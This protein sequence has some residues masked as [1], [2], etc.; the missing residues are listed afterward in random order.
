MDLMLSSPAT[1]PMEHVW[2][3]ED[4][5]VLYARTFTG[6]VFQTG[7]F[8][9]WEPAANPPAPPPMQRAS[10]VRL[11]EPGAEIFTASNNPS[12]LWAR[13]RQLSRSDDGGRSWVDLT[14]YRSQSVVGPGQRSVAVSPSDADQIV[15]ANDYGVWRSMDGGL[16]WAGLNES[17]PN[18]AVRRIVSTPTGVAGTRVAVENLGVLE[19]PHGGNVW[20][21][22]PNIHLDEGTKTQQYSAIVRADVTAFGRSDEVVFAGSGDG[23]IWVS[24]DGGASFDLTTMPSG[25]TGRVERIYVNAQGSRVVALAALS[26]SGPRVLRTTNGGQFWDVLDFNLPAGSAYA[27]TA[28]RAAGAVFVATDKGVYY[29][30]AD[31]EGASTNPVNWQNLTGGLPA[32][33]AMDV[34]L[35]PAAVQ[36][37]IALEGYGVY[38]ASAPHRRNSLQ[39]VNAA[40][41]STRAAAPGSLLSVI[42]MG[43]NAAAGGG[44][45]YPVLAN[46]LGE[47]QIQVPFEAEGPNVAL[48]LQTASGRVLRD[49]A[50]QPVSPAILLLDREG[51]PALYD[52]DSGLALDGRNAA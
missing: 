13:G 8:E 40:D 32:A 34:M 4:G 26:G 3:S 2:Y 27:V 17:L 10:A 12:R 52:A 24:R 11:P 38:A 36:L 20:R 48:A 22:A 29:G 16:S 6:R 50:V 33:R 35:D 23:R 5:S 14:A 21:P 25:T 42:G 7:D 43:V 31:L 44:L 46:P 18:L 51:T 45:N 30:H 49:L 41:F 37:Y 47:S 28:D 15:V 19:L 9:T 39:I 1:G